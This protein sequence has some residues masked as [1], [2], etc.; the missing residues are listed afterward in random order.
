MDLPDNIL[1]HYL[2][3]VYFIAGGLCGGK[4]TI[5]THLSQKY[6]IALYNWDEK[7]AEHIASSDPLHQSE[8]HRHGGDWEAHFSRFPLSGQPHWNDQFVNMSTSRL[9]IS[10][11]EQTTT[12]SSS[13]ESSH[14]R[15]WNASLSQNGVCFSTPPWSGSGG[16]TFGVRISKICKHALCD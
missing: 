1:R 3:N 12:S 13:T 8:M 6:G 15:F 14:V 2:R 10:S 5:S 9:W 11:I 7:Y 16:I 4:T